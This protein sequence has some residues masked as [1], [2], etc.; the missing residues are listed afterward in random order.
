MTSSVSSRRV[1]WLALLALILIWGFNFT[2]MKTAMRY[3]GPFAFSALRYV[4]GTIVLFAL[5]AFRRKELKPPPWGATIVIGL[6]QTLGF[7][8]LMQLA[9]V[10][11]GAGKVAMFVYTMPFWVVPIAWGLL[12]EKPGRL[13]WACI[14][15]AALGVV[16]IIAPWR[17]VSKPLAIGLAL[18]AGLSWAMAVVISKRVFERHP[19][20]TALQLTAWQMLPGTIALVILALAIPERSIA[21]TP[22]YLFAIAYTGVLASAV[23][24]LAWALIVQ[25]LPAGASGLMALAVPVAGVLFAWGLL[26]EQPSLA[27]GIG[28]ILIAAAL[29]S[30]N[31]TQRAP[32]SQPSRQNPTS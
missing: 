12:H 29:L 2:V 20:V 5:L 27:E 10:R 11:G 21:W 13:R 18:G 8:A 32:A 7:Q 25:R 6:C 1:V 15:L 30:L 22:E 28:I 16:C 24:W 23:C 3:S 17:G 14:G 9:M 26:G 31:F 19:D 4:L